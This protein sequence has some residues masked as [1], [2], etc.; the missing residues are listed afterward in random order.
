VGATVNTLS[1]LSLDPNA[2]I[3]SAKSFVCELRA[4]RLGTG[5]PP[6]PLPSVSRPLVQNPIPDTAGAAQPLG[7]FGHGE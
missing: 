2:D 3:H 4:G 7:R 5:R 6:E 1:L